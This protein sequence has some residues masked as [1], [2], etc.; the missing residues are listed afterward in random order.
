V[1]VVVVA[2]ILSLPLYTHHD[3]GTRL[4][5]PVRLCLGIQQFGCVGRLAT[6]WRLSRYSWYS[7]TEY[8]TLAGTSH[9]AM[10]EQGDLFGSVVQVSLQKHDP[11]PTVGQ[12]VQL[13]VQLLAALARLPG[14][15]HLKHKQ[16]CLLRNHPHKPHHSFPRHVNR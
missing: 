16:N 14:P 3:T 12:L 8:T 9:Y 5:R 4:T 6:P 15:R 11:D 13:S 7:N 2:I 1:V 10:V